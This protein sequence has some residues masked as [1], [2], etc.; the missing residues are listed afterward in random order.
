MKL[1]IGRCSTR[2]H[3]RSSRRHHHHHHG[4]ELRNRILAS[5]QPLRPHFPDIVPHYDPTG[6]HVAFRSSSS[7]VYTSSVATAAATAVS[8]LADSSVG[9]TISDISA[10]ATTATGVSPWRFLVIFMLGGLFFSTALAFGVAFYTFGVDNVKRFT[11]IGLLIVSKVWDSFVLA[12]SL[13]RKELLGIESDTETTIDTTTADGDELESSDLFLKQQQQQKQQVEKKQWKWKDAW[14]VLK[15]QLAETRKTATEGVEA[16]KQESTLYAAAVGQPGLLPIQ[17]AVNKLF[18]YSLTTILEDS[19]KDSLRG[20]EP[21]KTIKRMKVNRFT[22][23]DRSPVFQGARMYEIEDA[24]AFDFDV[25]WESELEAEIQIYTVGG[26]KLLPV[27]I[28]KLKF[29]GVVR[30]V[31]TPL[32]KEPPGYGAMLISLTSPPDLSLDVKVLG[33]ELTKFRFLKSEITQVMQQAVVDNL[34]WPKRNV[35]PIK[36]ETSTSA[37]PFGTG[38]GYGQ[39]LKNEQLRVLQTID[40]LLATEQKLANSDQQLVREVNQKRKQLDTEKGDREIVINEQDDSA[41]TNNTTDTTTTTNTNNDDDENSTAG[42]TTNVGAEQTPWWNNIRK[43][44]GG[45]AAA[46]TT[47]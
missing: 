28:K 29:A 6:A 14:H 1:P 11:K 10:A 3:S 44:F 15:A 17:Y 27:L 37:G 19:L 12:L 4:Q 34:L 25:K 20:I 8:G 18:P 2:R 21:T 38:V 9:T 39:L 7:Y 35:I 33:A 40:P 43:V 22:A 46:T 31:L 26:F 16:L 24:M 32:I 42:E 41:E 36:S 13:A 45:Q 30:V 47:T 23:G 5:V